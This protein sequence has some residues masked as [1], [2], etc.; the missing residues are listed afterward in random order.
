MLGTALGG[1]CTRIRRSRTTAR[2]GLGPKIKAGYVFAVEPMVNQ[3]THFNEGFGGWVD[4]VT[5]DGNAE[6]PR[7]AHHRDY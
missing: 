3:G 7:R 2:P 4:G 6:R 5:I 1:A